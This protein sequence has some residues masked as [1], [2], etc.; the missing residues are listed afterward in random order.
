M[1]RTFYILFFISVFAGSLNAQ[2]GHTHSHDEEATDQN[3]LQSKG[4]FTIYAETGKYELTLKHDKI[5][6]GEE[7]EMTLY[8]ADY[9][10]N[11]PLSNVD[12]K[13]SAQ[14]DPS[15]V[16][17]T[18][19]SE[20]G[21]YHLHATYP[22]AKPY[23]L[24]VNINAPG[25]GPDLML[26][27]NVEVGM[28][29]PSSELEEAGVEYEHSDWWKFIAVFVAGLGIGYLFLRRRP[30][31]AA[32][33]LMILAVH[34]LIQEAQAH[35]EPNAKK[36]NAGNEVFIP[37][38]TQFLFD[39]VTQQVALG[40]FQPS[41][42][43]FGTVV[44]SPSGYAE[45]TAPQ[46]GRVTSLKVAP[47][48]KV[49]AG[50]IVA[51]ILPSASLSERVGVATETGRLNADLQTARAELNAAEAELNRLKAIEDIVAKKEVQAAQA[52]YNAAKSN[53]ESLRSVASGSS[54]TSSGS[55]TLKAP[56][57]GTV[58]QFALAPGAEIV[59][60]TKLFSITNLDKVFV[61]AQVYDNDA[62]VVRNASKYTVT[63][64]NDEHETAQVRLVSA[65]M[66]VN[67]SNQSQKV[68][69]EVINPGDDFKLGEFVTLQAF[70][71]GVGKTIFVVNSALSEINGK[72][73]IFVKDGPEKYSVRFISL[74][75][76]NGTHTVVLKG[77]EES[78]RFVTGSTY[79][80]KTMM[81]NQ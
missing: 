1:H 69:F 31:V 65:A 71:E 19:E 20:P 70:Q 67:P 77:I 79:Q 43:F 17:T 25:Y 73:V 63:C 58:G 16:V 61:E 23:A 40:N 62:D 37:K 45:I 59:T 35:G 10:T 50:Q 68:L 51:E 78:E 4:M 13:I 6:P 14:A 8:I 47:G 53:Y 72:P 30:K 33:I 75:D 74:G 22:E 46:G 64:T 39:V 3:G 5:E 57:S 11:E 32:S 2:D 12:L 21:V 48:Q 18:E 41:I 80:V 24:A 26:L 54:V 15:L 55:I 36:G 76:D 7:G 29:P 52:R 49:N 66:E 38:Q 44:P 56:V 27:S 81:L 28:E 42:E 9:K 60:G 34:A